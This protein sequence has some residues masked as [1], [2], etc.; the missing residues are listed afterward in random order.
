MKNLVE[1]TRKIYGE[2]PPAFWT[3][4]II[5]FIDRLGGFMLYPFFA[6]YLTQKY[7]IGMALVHKRIDKRGVRM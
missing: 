7:Q 6:L 1:K 2:Y 4:N 3:Y 5:I